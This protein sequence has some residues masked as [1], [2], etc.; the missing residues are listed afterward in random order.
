MSATTQP[1]ATKP[2]PTSI[3]GLILAVA[4]VIFGLTVADSF[5]EKAEQRELQSQAE[6]AYRE[7]T[8]LL[9][10][11][12][13]NQAVDQLRKA[14]ALERSNSQYELQLVD[15]LIAA[16]KTTEAEPLMDELLVREPNDGRVNLSAARLML[17]R[18]QTVEAVSYYHRAIY[19]DWSQ[20]AAAHRISTRMEL[21]NVLVAKSRYEELL[22]ELLPLEE[23]AGKNP[24]IQKNLAHLFLVAGSPSRAA[25]AYRTQIA[26]NPKDAEAYEGLGE[27]ELAQGQYHAAHTAFAAALRHKPGDTSIQPRLELA[28]T[29][30]EL[31]P[32]PRRLSSMEKYRRSLHILQLAYTGLQSCFAKTGAAPSSKIAQLLTAAQATIANTNPADVANELS[33]AVLGLTQKIWEARVEICG[34][35]VSSDDEPLRLIMNNLAQ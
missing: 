2:T 15:A 12:D 10:R 1:T 28:S 16:G 20:D 31:D 11:G 19:G 18:N 22:A 14:Q 5:L 29:L 6:R 34:A 21:V 24:A 23:E 4:L 8:R 25:D 7:G 35:N 9:A 17:K 33:E 32:T 13:A 30:T 26:H 27:A 3:L